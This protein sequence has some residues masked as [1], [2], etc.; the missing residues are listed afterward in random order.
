MSDD[1]RLLLDEIERLQ[2][3]YVGASEFYKSLLRQHNVPFQ[4]IEEDWYEEARARIVERA[5]A[6]KA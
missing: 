6:Y 3:N 1:V 2:E 5:R 4:S